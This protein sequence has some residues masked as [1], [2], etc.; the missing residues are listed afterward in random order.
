MTSE[1]TRNA[2]LVAPL[3]RQRMKAVQRRDTPAELT[4]R[5]V[6]HGLGLRFRVCDASLP[7][8][9]DIV[10][11]RHAVCVFV[12]GCFWHRHKNCKRASLPKSNRAFWNDKFA[13]N[14]A[15]D[16]RKTAA[17]RAM[18]WRVITFWECQTRNRDAV[19]QRIARVFG[20]AALKLPRKRRR[21]PEHTRAAK[22][23]RW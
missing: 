3:V 6:A 8:S 15:R 21:V 19:E 11:P 13:R 4:V 14:V 5:S 18:N 10:F 22:P 12:H 20:K 7:G 23:Y 1:R 9:P 17:L 16:K 2:D